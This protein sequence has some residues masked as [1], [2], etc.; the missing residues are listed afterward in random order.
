[1]IKSLA[2][3]IYDLKENGHFDEYSS[4]H[5]IIKAFNNEFSRFT[6]CPFFFERELQVLGKSNSCDGLNFLINLS[7]KL[8]F[9][10]K[11]F[12]EKSLLEFV[13][14]QFAAGKNNYDE[15]QFF[16]AL[17][18]L[19]VINYLS[20][21]VSLKTEGQ[22]E[23][24][25]IEGSKTNPEARLIF[26]G[27]DFI[28]DI[29]VKTG[30]FKESLNLDF[31]PEKHFRPNA[32]LSPKDL[33]EL[34]KTSEDLDVRFHSPNILKLKDFIESA[35]TKF[36]SLNEPNRLNLL[37]IN[38]SY[39]DFKSTGLLEPI[40]LLINSDSGLLYSANA[41]KLISLPSSALE[42][43]SGIIFYSDNVQSIIS[44][45]FR[46]HFADNSVFLIPVNMDKKSV[47]EFT[48]KTNIGLVNQNLSFLANRSISLRQDIVTD[49]LLCSMQMVMQK[50]V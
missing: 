41:R 39:N 42:N 22:Y 44:S 28:Y 6:N 36:L 45:D 8:S 47:I 21:Y 15:E 26:D 49:S 20:Q 37:F 1:M 43:I 17:S 24:K 3:K 7:S 33:K 13:K 29:E 40:S 14:E 31:S 34:K 46:Y 5:I 23:P 35:S 18:E 19:H 48:K 50:R 30:A 27:G 9:F 4:D 12:G 2:K 16:R 38:W 25:L 32:I 10:E 11:V